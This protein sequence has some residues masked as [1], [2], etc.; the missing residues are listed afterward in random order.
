M[1]RRKNKKLKAIGLAPGSLVY[2]GDKVGGGGAKL[3]LFEYS[4]TAIVEKEVTLEQ[5]CLAYRNSPNVFWLNIDGV[6]DVAVV[7]KLGK[8]FGIHPLVLEDIL[9]AGHRP[10]KEEHDEYIFISL[11]M[12]SRNK[13]STDIVTEQ[14]SLIIGHNFVLSFQEGSEGDVFDIVRQRLRSGKGRLRRTGADYLGYALV[15]LIIDNYFIVLEALGEK[16]ELLEDRLMQS[17]DPDVIQEINTARKEMVLFRRAVWPVRDIVTSLLRDESPIIREST[18]VYL[19]DVYDH[20][21]EVLEIGEMLREMVSLM[22][23]L[24]LTNISNRTNE[25]MKVLA[26][27][28]TIF[29]PLTFISSIYGMNFEH[30]PEL[31]WTFGYPLAVSLMLA[32]ALALL[33]FFRKREWM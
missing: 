29:M 5:A 9:D 27:I 11:K 6:H 21:I 8:H 20:I 18:V 26:L 33:I 4:E 32:I 15:D 31:R 25:I 1:A 19:R 12:L 2:T 3:T 10:K 17:R 14:V 23:E 13:S 7:D 22:V 28:S 24:Y 30:M 16:Y